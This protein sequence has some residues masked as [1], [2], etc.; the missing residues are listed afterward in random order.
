MALTDFVLKLSELQSQCSST[1]GHPDHRTMG[2]SN[3]KEICGQILSQ[4]LL[5]P[6]V[7]HF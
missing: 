3:G 6:Y 1:A 5:L 2:S 7:P 4:I